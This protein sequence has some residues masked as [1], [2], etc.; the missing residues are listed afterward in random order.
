MLLP[1]RGRSQ[2]GPRA[3]R[4]ILAPGKTPGA[5]IAET[6]ADAMHLH[7]NHWPPFG[8]AMPRALR[9]VT[10]A[11]LDARPALMQRSLCGRSA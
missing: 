6:I 4:K 9:S 1:L 3:G 2:R 10:M 8:V 11:L 7:R 5:I